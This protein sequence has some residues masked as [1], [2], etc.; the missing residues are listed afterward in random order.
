MPFDFEIRITSA[1]DLPAEFAAGA[2][3]ANVAA[4]L[5]C[6]AARR[7]TL[8]HAQ[9]NDWIHPPERAG[10]Q[11]ALAASNRTAVSRA[12][13][14]RNR[15]GASLRAAMPLRALLSL[16][17]LRHEKAEV[18]PF[19]AKAHFETETGRQ[20]ALSE[21]G[22]L[23]RDGEPRGASFLVAGDL[24]ACSAGKRRGGAF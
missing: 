3:A 18:S 22:S 7:E 4:H 19:C 12:N 24:N 5:E 1:E 15:S 23:R 11:R 14:R 21:A 9:A 10:A 13:F 6:P 16:A 8:A 17:F 20:G 2:K